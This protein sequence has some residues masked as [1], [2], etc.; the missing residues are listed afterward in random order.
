MVWAMHSFQILICWK[1]A[2]HS[3]FLRI[4][5]CASPTL[6]HYFR[7]ACK[8][9]FLCV[10]RFFH[11]LDHVILFSLFH[12]SIIGWSDE[13]KRLLVWSSELYNLATLV[14]QTRPIYFSMQVTQD[15]SSQSI[16]WRPF[17]GRRATLWFDNWEVFKAEK[18]F[19]KWCTDRSLHFLENQ[20]CHIINLMKLIF[21]STEMT[22]A[23]VAFHPM[24][25]MW[26]SDSR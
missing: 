8:E 11:L 10:H 20:K 18:Q 12:D 26:G 9:R 21:S 22:E 23:M 1:G 6:F 16:D 2:T 5:K 15:Q 13:V 7:R 24:Q 19:T 4:L 25:F 3:F 14:L 17:L